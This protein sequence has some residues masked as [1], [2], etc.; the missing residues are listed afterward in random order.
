MTTEHIILGAGCFWG[1]EAVFRRVPG[2]TDAI[3]GYAGGHAPNPDYR[4]VCSGTTGHAEVV[5]ITYDSMTVSL[6]ELL[7]VFWNCHDPTTLNRQGPDIG[8]QYRSAIY[9]F[10]ADQET[11]AQRSRAQAQ[12][13]GRWPDPIVTEILPASQ[14][15]P[16][17]NYHQRYFEKH[18]LQH[19]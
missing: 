10:T 7:E 5:R 4:A 2:V 18:G 11:A 6:E 14:F 13:S 12:Q 16:A 19:G 15:Y 3:C 17:E 8:S 1:V 9:F